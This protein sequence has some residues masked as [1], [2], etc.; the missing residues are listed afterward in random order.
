M[1]F[2]V[3]GDCILDHNIYTIVQTP[4]RI[5]YN[6]EYNIISEEYKLGACGNLVTN[7]QALGAN[8]VFLFSAIGDDDAGQR[9]SKMADS[10]NICNFLKT[11]PSYN[12]TVKHRHYCDN[13][14]IFQSANNINKELLLPIS[15]CDE[16]EKVLIHTKI[17]CIV[18]CESEKSSIGLL[19][20]QHCQK[21][22]ALAT[23]YNIPTIV[24]PKEDIY[25]YRGCTIIKP[26]RDEA[27]ALMNMPKDAPL[28]DVHNEILQQIQCKYSYIT[29]S[30]Q[31][32]SIYDGKDEIC[33]K[34]HDDLIVVD[35]IGAGDIITSITALLFNKVDMKDGAHIA[36]NMA[37]KSVEKTGVVTVSNRDIVNFRFASKHIQFNDLPTLRTL[38]YNKKI[39]ITT[40][41]F[42]LLHDG[43]ILSLGWC[44]ENCDILVVCLN[45]DESIQQ[46]KGKQ[47]PIQSIQSRLSA[48]IALD[49][50]DYVL[51]FDQPNAVEI[52]KMLKPNVLMKGGDYRDKHM[53][54]SDFVDTTL[55]GPYLDGVSTTNIIKNM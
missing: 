6:T 34:C 10:L 48:L 7:L 35:P 2:I 31:G 40:G 39:G 18:L 25:K 42:D 47:R 33:D 4:K 43:H 8:K 46:L 14:C 26:N 32:I 27:Y 1:N 52:I 21:I 3:I 15:L 29:L 20:I 53:L 49:I 17:D 5:D 45:S 24:D 37:S 12:T 19:S 13:K 22:I 28:M 50:V 30:E 44:K 23:K 54:E 38:F 16:I 55:I 36:V 41:C 9:M 11:V 51:V